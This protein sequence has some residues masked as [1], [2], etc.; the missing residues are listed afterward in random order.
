M[1][2]LQRGESNAAVAPR[3]QGRQFRFQS[4]AHRRRFAGRFRTRCGFRPADDLPAQA[5]LFGRSGEMASSF[6]E[7]T[8]IALFSARKRAAAS[9]SVR[10]CASSEWTI[11]PARSRACVTWPRLLIAA[12]FVRRGGSP[13]P[14][15]AF[16]TSP[17]RIE[18]PRPGGTG[19]RPAE[20]C[21]TGPGRTDTVA[22]F[23]AGSSGSSWQGERA[24]GAEAAGEGHCAAA[25]GR[26]MA[27][28]R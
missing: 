18:Q 3:Q 14:A 27:G 1:D 5:F 26:V 24:G 2:R 8:P 15:R 17:G 4:L 12:A 11:S 19:S 23:M 16:S 20:S 28:P 7:A 21:P 25:R 22:I 6:S 9:I 13:H 10:R